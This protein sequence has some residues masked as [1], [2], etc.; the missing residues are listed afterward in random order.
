MRDRS[1]AFERQ[2]DPRFFQEHQL[3]SRIKREFFLP[4]NRSAGGNPAEIGQCAE[5][6]AQ[7]SLDREV[8]RR[9]N[10]LCD[11]HFTADAF[12]EPAADPWR[13]LPGTDPGLTFFPGRRRQG[14]PRRTVAERRIERGRQA[15]VN[16]I[17]RH[18]L[19][20]R[21]VVPGAELFQI[22]QQHAGRFGPVGRP[23]DP[24][25]VHRIFLNEIVDPLLHH[26]DRLPEFLRPVAQHAQRRAQTVIAA[27]RRPVIFPAQPE[28]R[29]RFPQDRFDHPP[30]HIFPDDPDQIRGNGRQFVFQQIQRLR[31]RH[32]GLGG[33]KIDDIGRRFRQRILFHVAMRRQTPGVFRGDFPQIIHDFVQVFPLIFEDF[34]QHQR[35]KIGAA[36]EIA[37]LVTPPVAV[38]DEIHEQR[39][40]HSRHRFIQQPVRHPDQFARHFP[41]AGD[42]QHGLPGFPVG[43]RREKRSR[44]D[45][46]RNCG[47]ALRF[48][49]RSPGQ[50]FLSGKLVCCGR[51][52][53]ESKSRLNFS[54]SARQRPSISSRYSHGFQPRSR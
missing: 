21:T 20:L 2:G 6:I 11:Q 9:G 15:G 46:C 31:Q 42:L 1:A 35:T 7:Q 23:L 48:H 37:D 26:G 50:L 44:V 33:K 39:R 5:Q 25:A 12:P 40:G 47:S 41:V 24:A 38:A 13:D 52:P 18:R 28:I 27:P 16:D 19:D 14:D 22:M 51:Q 45:F 54:A 8:P 4:E 43:G 36:V 32:A 30:F 29:E 10:S 3:G 53:S 34:R 49:R 17:F